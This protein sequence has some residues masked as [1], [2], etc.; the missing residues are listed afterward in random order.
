MYFKHLD[1]VD[2][3]HVRYPILKTRTLVNG[4]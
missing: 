1:E 2:V 3:S 4:S